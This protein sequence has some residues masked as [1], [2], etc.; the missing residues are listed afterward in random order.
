L[1]K[2]NVLSTKATMKPTTATTIARMAV[3]SETIASRRLLIQAVC[4]RVLG[5]AS[6]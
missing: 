5:D 1:S 3:V 6:E 2:K 4:H